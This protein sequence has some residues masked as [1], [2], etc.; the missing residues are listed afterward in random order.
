MKTLEELES[1]LQSLVED[2]LVKAIPGYSTMDR[3]P[4]LLAA[5]MHGS[6]VQ[7]GTYIKA[8]NI[9]TLIAHPTT[10]THWNSDRLLLEELAGAIEK[11]G[12]EAGC[13]FSTHPRVT[14]AADASM[15]PDTVRILASFSTEPLSE[16]RGIPTIK[17]SGKNGGEEPEPV[18]EPIPSNAFLIL[19]GTRIIPLKT[20]VINIGR[21][22]DNHLV[23]DDP[24]ISRTHAQIRIVKGR[25]VLFDLESTG[26]TFVNDQRS[27]QTVL[28]PGDVISLA[29]VS[30]I[31]GQDLPTGRVPEDRTE[32]G[33]SVS[34]DRPTA[35]L[36]NSPDP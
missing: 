25:F 13:K 12:I 35:V 16:T 30:L 14:S 22:L 11:T 20:S 23:I 21:R 28:Y 3:V 26:G 9:Y 18:I 27:S 1:Q 36:K 15:K 5:A 6:L 4:H 32:A 33:P 31:F 34:G 29:G 10:L 19:G 17:E 8:P 2:H 24:R 7:R